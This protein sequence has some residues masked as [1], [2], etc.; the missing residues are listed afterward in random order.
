MKKK[1]LSWIIDLSKQISLSQKTLFVT[2]LIIGCVFLSGCVGQKKVYHVGILSG[3]PPFNDVGDGFK[4]GM[5]ELGYIEGENIIYDFQKLSGDPGEI[6]QIL[7]KFVEDEVDLIFAFPT[8]PALIAKTS[9]QGTGI[10]VVF[11]MGTIEGNDLVESLRQPGGNVT[12]ARYCGP[13]MFVKTLEFLLDL[14]APAFETWHHKYRNDGA[15]DADDG[16]NDKVAILVPK[17]FGRGRR[18]LNQHNDRRNRRHDSRRRSI[19]RESRWHISG[20]GGRSLG[21][22]LNGEGQKK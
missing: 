9:T 15:N 17:A 11:A 19:G 6:N 16:T 4:E 2:L 21:T 12:G 20:D 22:S 1:L 3:A 14:L 10:P 8:E 5:T 18:L 13:D 7:N